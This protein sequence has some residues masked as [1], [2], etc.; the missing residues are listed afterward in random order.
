MA[1][2]INNHRLVKKEHSAAFKSDKAFYF[3]KVT[4]PPLAIATLRIS[5]DNTR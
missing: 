1:A 5:R 2:A 4:N 3:L